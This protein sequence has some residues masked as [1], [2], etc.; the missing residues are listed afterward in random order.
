MTFTRDLTWQNLDLEY[1]SSIA[2]QFA[3]YALGLKYSSLPA[4]VVHQA[5][6][7]LLDGLG[8][9]IGSYNAP[10]R[11]ACEAMAKELGGP[12]E[13]TVFGSGLRTSALNASLVNGF[14]VC[15]LGFNDVGG[16]GHNSAGIAATLAISE[17]E[18]AAGGDFLTSLI[19]SYE[20][21]ARFAEGI[22]GPSLEERG[23]NY[24]MRAGLS[25]PPTLGRL[26]GLNEDQIAN[27]IGICASRSLPLGVLDCHREEITMAKGLTFGFVAY[28]SILACVLAKQGFTGP[29]RVVE[30]DSGI[31]Q[32]I[33]QGDMDLE[34]M[35]DFS[36]WKILGTWHKTL[37]PSP[38]L[39][40]HAF[41]TLD[42][43]V[44]H[45]LKPDDIESV[46]IK[47][48]PRVFQHTTA[49]SRKYPRNPES[50]HHSAFYPNAIAIKE[51]SCGP[52]Q[53]A[54]EKLDDPVVLDLIDR[55]TVEPDPDLPKYVGVSEIRTR[56]GRR[57]EKRTDV[58]HGVVDD[59]LSD[60]EIEE[61]FRMMSTKYMGDGQIQEI[62]DMVW[63][64]E[65]LDDVSKLTELM[66]FQDR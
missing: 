64:I 39:F 18:K 20:L 11:P 5:K 7:S 50:A 65:R 31:R 53:F 63:N 19:I 26:M 51:R 2:Y 28:D 10:G 48:G 40:W 8:C 12:Q 21:G 52:D 38:T 14:L 15:Y 49:L 54:V 33:L 3:R 56:D 30:G 60:G 22:T 29:I 42:L 46:N 17:R 61:K 23:W 35:T 43:V 9:A 4:K 66:V 32:S 62:V 45:D 58:P 36:R 1:R 25:M 41:A 24:D 16:G 59:P 47:A 6:R 57:F 34:R 44:A 37:G 27:A 55:I 13:A